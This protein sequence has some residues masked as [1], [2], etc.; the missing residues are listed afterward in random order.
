MTDG[1][2]QRSSEP[3]PATEG[4]QSFANYLEVLFRW[5]RFIFIN[6]VV[7]GLLTA[8]I[9]FILPKWYRA[10]ASILP[11]KEQNLLNISGSAPALKGLGALSRLG[12]MNQGGGEY[13]YFAILKS[14]SAMEEMVRRF[15]LMDVYGISDTAMMDEAIKELKS[16]VAFETQEDDNITID[17]FDKNPVRAAEMANAFVE[18]LNRRSI[19]LGTQEAKNN[20]VFIEQRIGRH[21]DS[22]RRVEDALKTFQEHSGIMITPEQTASANAIAELYGMK[23]RKAIEVAILRRTVGPD[24]PS[25]RQGEIELSEIERQLDSIPQT[26]LRAVRLYRDVVTEEKILEFLMPLYEQAKIDEQKDVPVLLVLDKAM[27]PEKKARP[28]RM[29]IILSVTL[30]FLM[31]SILLVYLMEGIERRQFYAGVL[32]RKLSRWVD[33]V[34]RFYRIPVAS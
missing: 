2:Q 8:A 29:L 31:F 34:I 12:G 32:Q 7:V 4:K 28:Q 27:P 6:V 22:L 9:C 3:A 26:G 16:N 18:I 5:R 19:E 1:I 23:E 14:R 13:N 15:H 24:N 10:T 17:V 20:R 11:P 21:Q 25:L 30:L 33:R